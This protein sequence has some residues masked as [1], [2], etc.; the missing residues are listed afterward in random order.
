MQVAQNCK[1]G[2][3][4]QWTALRNSGV[5]GLYN[6]SHLKNHR[7]PC[8]KYSDE[9]VM[10]LIGGCISGEN[11]FIFYFFIWSG[12]YNLEIIF[13]FGITGKIKN[14]SHDPFSYDNILQNSSCVYPI[15]APA[16]PSA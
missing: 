7:E 5:W 2:P 13:Q 14:G 1:L 11:F 3:S 9:N 16:F 12:H 4:G 10:L 8:L 15:E 6:L